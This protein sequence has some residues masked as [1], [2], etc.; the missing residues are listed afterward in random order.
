MAQ[1]DLTHRDLPPPPPAVFLTQSSLIVVTITTF[2]LYGEL[3]SEPLKSS[4]VFSALALFNQL[5]VPLFILPI[6]VKAVIDARVS[7]GCCVV[8]CC[9][10]SLVISVV[11][12]P[13]MVRFLSDVSV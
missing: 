6:V 12:F 7:A 9:C 5:T 2:S 4:H 1:S 11:C 13:D 3:E 10:L 8:Y